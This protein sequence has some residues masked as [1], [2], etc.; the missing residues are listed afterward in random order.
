MREIFRER[1]NYL[2]QMYD[3]TQLKLAKASGITRQAISQYLDASTAPN[4]DK[5]YL[6]AKYFNVSADYLIGL[7][8]CAQLDG[9]SKENM[10]FNVKE[11]I[12][13][14]QLSIEKIVQ[15]LELLR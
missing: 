7:S 10:F 11:E 13:E 6:I 4:I 2:M 14:I 12:K 8:D 5:L 3:T 1:L 9:Q 15:K